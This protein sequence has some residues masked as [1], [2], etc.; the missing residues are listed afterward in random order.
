MK[1][2]KTIIIIFIIMLILSIWIWIYFMIAQWHEKKIKE[3]NNNKMIIQD[4]NIKAEKEGIKNEKIVNKQQKIVNLKIDIKV[5]DKNDSNISDEI[6]WK[7][8]NIISKWPLK[9]SFTF[10]W[11]MKYLDKI[12]GWYVF[13]DD[14]HKKVWI[15]NKPKLINI[16]NKRLNWYKPSIEKIDLWE[17]DRYYFVDYD[18]IILKVIQ[19]WKDIDEL[20]RIWKSI[21]RYL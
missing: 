18:L 19:N 5:Y 15:F 21:L 20:N 14:F 16:F 2:K 3:K 6:I 17:G 11:E 9:S 1:S 12:N 8:N 13:N 4:I 7:I 10:K